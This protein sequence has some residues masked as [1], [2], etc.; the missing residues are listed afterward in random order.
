[1]ALGAESG[2]AAYHRLYDSLQVSS[3]NW[4]PGQT[5][6]LSLTFIQKFG[7][8]T[9][10]MTE[11]FLPRSTYVFPAG[12]AQLLTLY[13]VSL[14]AASVYYYWRNSSSSSP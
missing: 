7:E 10:T 2:D 4:R 3:D 12:T 13:A 8:Y 1:M 9:S 11:Q 6:A 14:C 5:F